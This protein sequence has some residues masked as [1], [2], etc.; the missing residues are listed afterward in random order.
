MLE[1]LSSGHILVLKRVYLP[2]PCISVLGWRGQQGSSCESPGGRRACQHQW[3]S[4]EWLQTRGN[5][6]GERLPQDPQPRGEKVGDLSFASA[7]V[8]SALPSHRNGSPWL[9]FQHMRVTGAELGHC[10]LSTGQTLSLAYLSGLCGW[11]VLLAVY[12]LSN[13]WSVVV[14]LIYSTDLSL[15][16]FFWFCQSPCCL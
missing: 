11:M 15:F 13:S 14:E 4:P 9:H 7:A 5:L 10:F 2:F 6:P 8:A 3:G 1:L 16:F 12:T